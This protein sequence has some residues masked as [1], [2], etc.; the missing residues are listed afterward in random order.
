LIIISPFLVRLFTGRFATA[1]T[2]WPFII[3]RSQHDVQNKSLIIHER[4]HLRQQAELLVVFFY[5]WY[6]IEYLIYRIQ[7]KTHFEAYRSISF[8]KEAYTNEW[9]QDYPAGRSYFA[10]L[11]YIRK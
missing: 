2:L 6:L 4:I 8:E 3:L 5:L 7:G 11:K 9:K 10:F 1:I